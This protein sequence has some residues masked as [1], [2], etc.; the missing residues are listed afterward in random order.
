MLLLMADAVTAHRGMDKKSSA[1]YAHQVR[2]QQ[3]L[4]MQALYQQY[5]QQRTNDPDSR[6]STN[7]PDTP[8]L[9]ELFILHEHRPQTFGE[10]TFSYDSC[11]YMRVCIDTSVSHNFISEEKAMSMEFPDRTPSRGKKPWL[12]K[13]NRKVHAPSHHIELPTLPGYTPEKRATDNLGRMRIYLQDNESGVH[14]EI[15]CWVA[16]GLLYDV[17]I[18]NDCSQYVTL[19]K[20]H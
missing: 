17:V 11:G 16:K 10:S 13:Q 8:E 1:E 14:H 20:K 12:S 3:S 4:E 6:Q 19:K 2:T 7:D 15:D 18:G 9:L 5:S